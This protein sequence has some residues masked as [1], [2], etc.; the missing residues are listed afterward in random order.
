MITFEISLETQNFQEETPSPVMGAMEKQEDGQEAKGRRE[1]TGKGLL[2]L[3][4]EL[5]RA[6]SRFK[7]NSCE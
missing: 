4:K 1:N 3:L 5:G 6:G 2:K 7:F